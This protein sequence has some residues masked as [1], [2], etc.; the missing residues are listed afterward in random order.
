[1]DP[2][3]L[4]T[5]EITSLRPANIFPPPQICTYKIGLEALAYKS[6]V[7]K[8]NF[9]VGIASLLWKENGNCFIANNDYFMFWY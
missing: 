2:L 6:Q 5:M 8:E 4:E 1:M 7:Y 3:S 9:N